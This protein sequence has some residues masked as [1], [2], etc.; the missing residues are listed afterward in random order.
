MTS[1]MQKIGYQIF[2]LMYI[3]EKPTC[4]QEMPKASALCFLNKEK[5]E[6]KFDE[7]FET[8]SCSTGNKGEE[9]C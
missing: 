7:L 3:L 4:E 1:K 6:K 8:F 5:A 2:I 9:F